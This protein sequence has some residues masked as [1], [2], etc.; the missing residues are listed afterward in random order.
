M[1]L[2][3]Q[4][5]EVEEL[6]VEHGGDLARPRCDRLMAAGDVDDAEAAHA[7]GDTRV[8]AVPRL[9]GATVLDR[10]GHG[11]ERRRPHR[12]RSRIA[13]GDAADS[14]HARPTEWT[15]PT[16]SR[17]LELMRNGSLG[18]DA[19]ILIISPMRNEAAHVA[20]VARALAAQTHQPAEW[21]VVD[22]ASTDDTARDCASSQASIP[23]LQASTPA[24]PTPN[25]SSTGWPSPR[26]RV[27]STT[28][29]AR[30]SV[31]DWTHVMKLDGDI[32]LPPTTS[33]GSPR[34]VRARSRARHGGGEPD[35]A[36][37]AAA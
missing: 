33:S 25:P 30:A 1:Q 37:E 31:R 28:A 19:R 23:F 9:V 22:D 20:R 7:K 10:R 2:R 26:R 36:A 34:G 15:P 17:K 8:D 6:A 13:G 21:I 27:R 11:G 24:S 35:R 16:L 5:G 4:L 32:E 12:A 14:T 29:C 18:M 3:S